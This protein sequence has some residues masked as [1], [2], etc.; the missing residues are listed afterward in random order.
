MKL[1]YLTYLALLAACNAQVSTETARD[2][3][4]TDTSSPVDAPASVGVIWAADF[5]AS[6]FPLYNFTFESITPGHSMRAAMPGGGPGGRDAAQ[7]DLVPNTAEV[8]PYVGWSKQE[9]PETP[10]GA[11]RY[12]RLLIRVA[13]PCNPVGTFDTW[14]DKLII[15]GDGAGGRTRMV[16]GFGDPHTPYPPEQA[17]RI[18]LGALSRNIG[19][20][21]EE[22]TAHTDVTIGDWHWVQWEVR[23][24]STVD[25]DD[26]RIKVWIDHA[27]YALPTS[28]SDAMQLLTGVYDDET[29][30][31]VATNGW[32]NLALGHFVN[33]SLRSGQMR[34][35]VAG[36][37]FADAFDAHWAP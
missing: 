25:A 18:E 20:F 19:G 31:L 10:Q 5:S 12:I 22:A 37:E 7:I 35:Q 13:R 15:L 17:T 28:Q 29:G 21:P 23:S 30:E 16:A 24:S 4:A 3:T 11:T 34:I 14:T 33:T 32:N 36:F 27:A 26:G 1:A 6:R 9:L 8:Q 2:A